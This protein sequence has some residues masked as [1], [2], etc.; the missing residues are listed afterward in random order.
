MCLCIIYIYFFIFPPSC[1]CAVP[2]AGSSH[3]SP[4]GQMDFFLGF[5]SLLSL[6]HPKEW[7][8]QPA[9]GAKPP[10][11]FQCFGSWQSIP[12]FFHP[13]WYV[14][15][16]SSISLGA[17]QGFGGEWNNHRILEWFGLKG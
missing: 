11:L 6:L 9:A 2:V 5:P 12:G 10:T 4:K 1:G 14:F 16:V 13:Q 15:N 17:Q 7:K 8:C 3:V